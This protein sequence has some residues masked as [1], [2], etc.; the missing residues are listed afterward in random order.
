MPYRIKARYYADKDNFGESYVI[1]S[2]NEAPDS[3]LEIGAKVE[4]L[5]ME[6]VD[7]DMGGNLPQKVA[8]AFNEPS[9]ALENVDLDTTRDEPVEGP[10]FLTKEQ[11]PAS[12]QTCPIRRTCPTGVVVH[13]SEACHTDLENY[14]YSLRKQKEG[15]S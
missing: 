8:E 15:E 9:D 10:Q 5:P 4:L 13:D 12:C 11:L 1:T 3:K 6:S 2:T 7:V 14:Y